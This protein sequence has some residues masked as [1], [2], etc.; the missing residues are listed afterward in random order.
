MASC[1]KHPMALSEYVCGRCGHEFCPECVV[2]PYGLKKAPLCITCAL[3]AGGIRRQHTG[4]PKLS[5]RTVKDRLAEHRARAALAKPIP[6]PPKVK[7][8]P[9]K[10]WLEGE[11]RAEDVGGWSRK[12]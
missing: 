10:R 5:E 7:K 2:F 8:D 9:K 4:R 12:F 3:E 6:P 1:V 11:E